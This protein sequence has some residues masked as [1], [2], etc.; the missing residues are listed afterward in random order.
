MTMVSQVAF[1]R[2]EE[3]CKE[4]VYKEFDE[5]RRNAVKSAS[6]AQASVDGGAYE[7]Q[8]SF[9]LYGLLR[10]AMDKRSKTESLVQKLY[11]K[12]YFAHIEAHDEDSV[13]S[14]HYF[15]SDCEML[16]QM[17]QIGRNGVLI[18]FKQDKERPIS[19]ALFHCYQ[20][21]KGD[22]IQ[23]SAPGGKFHLIISPWIESIWQNYNAGQAC[24]G[25]SYGG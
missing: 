8:E 24:P 25:R 17:V 20:A 10:S 1:L 9:P 7:D 22:P 21:K 15:L 23:Y 2:S 3:Q 5:M 6:V 13:D 18:P 12:P 19:L 16:D 14:E 11:K 4:S